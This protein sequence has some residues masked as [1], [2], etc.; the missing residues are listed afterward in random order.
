M[1]GGR[2]GVTGRSAAWVH[3]GQGD[4][5]LVVD[6]Q[7]DFLPGGAL[8]VAQGDAIVPVLNGYIA[9][10]RARGLP[11]LAS[12]DWH[13]PKHCSFRV[14]GGP[15]PR[16]CIAGSSGAA[17]APEL[18]LPPEVEIFS[19]ATEPD[20][21]AYSA[22]QGTGL[23]EWLREHGCRR[24]FVGGL[25]TDYCVRASVL[26]ARGGGFAVLLLSDA[27]RAVE[28]APG[29]GARA[30][31]EMVAAGARPISLADLAETT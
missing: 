24:L 9:A 14:R 12:R 28:A 15:W 10:F 11:V 8:A 21:D 31:A 6:V 3:P 19:K 1:E 5:L 4:A 2:F 17:F 13:P 25:A 20:A 27:V 16:H 18:A 23:A 26:D 22:F 30:L 7:Q 29:D